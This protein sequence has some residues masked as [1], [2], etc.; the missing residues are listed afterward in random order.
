MS[1]RDILLDLLFPPKCPFCGKLLEKGELL[2]PDCQRDLPWLAGAGA[3][4]PVELTAGCI[5]VL[6]YQERVREAIHGYKFRGRSARS[7]T[8]GLL[9]AQALRDREATADLISWPSLSQKRLRQRGY[10]QARLLAEA[11]GK[12]LGMP[13]VRTLEKEDRPAQSGLQGEAERRANLLGAYTAVN[14]AGFQGKT[15]LLI[16]DVLTTGATLS[17]CAKTLLLA[18]AK[19]VRCATL[20]RAGRR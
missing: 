1:F 17:E 6:R 9:M 4:R 19:E 15:V 12:E 11:V 5:S 20:A 2:C 13:V 7:G 18:G 10:D 3:E 16:D 14:T 8:F